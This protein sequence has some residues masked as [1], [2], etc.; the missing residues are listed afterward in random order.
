MIERVGAGMKVL[1]GELC[2]LSISFFM[3]QFLHF[4][5]L[6]T[7]FYGYSRTDSDLIS[8]FKYSKDIKPGFFT[9]KVN[10]RSSR[11]VDRKRKKGRDSY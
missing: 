1:E 4:R 11:M 9:E 8:I 5:W 3:I 10:F 7:I 2:V 6:M